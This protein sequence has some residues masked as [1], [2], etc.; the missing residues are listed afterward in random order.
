MANVNLSEKERLL[1]M[2]TDFILTKKAVIDK[3]CVLLGEVAENYQKHLSQLAGHLPAEVVA[4]SP[5]ISRGEQYQGL[6]YVMLDYPRVFKGGDTFAVR[7]FFWWGNFFSITL[8]LSG[9]YKSNLIANLAKHQGTLAQKGWYICVST[10]P[11]RHH[12]EED[13]YLRIDGVT[14]LE[15]I[16]G[17]QSF[18]KIANKIP[19]QEWDSVNMLLFED[20]T[21]LFTALLEKH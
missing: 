9:Q 21:F 16:L 19:L 1:I 18:V 15:D 12:F 13:N 2:N 4:V 7:T 6:P 8:H 14:N 10:D 17:R 5:K 3:V 11:W 20:F